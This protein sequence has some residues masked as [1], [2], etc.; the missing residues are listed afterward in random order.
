M[1]SHPEFPATAA[2]VSY[3]DGNG[4]SIIHVFTSDG[5]TVTDKVWTG[6][7]WQAGTFSQPGHQVTAT[8]YVVSGMACLR[9][10]CISKE[11]LTEYGSDGGGSWYVGS[12]SYP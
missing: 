3:I 7:G 11:V 10:Y 6:S 8:A 9:V 1:A 4:Q 5:Y 2:A 12:Y